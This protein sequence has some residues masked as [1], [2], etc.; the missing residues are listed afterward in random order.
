MYQ[1]LH[2]M[3]WIWLHLLELQVAYLLYCP[4]FA[5]SLVSTLD[6]S[7]LYIVSNLDWL[8]LLSH[9]VAPSTSNS[10]NNHSLSSAISGTWL[11][12]C[13]IYHPL[14]VIASSMGTALCLSHLWSSPCIHASGQT[15][16]SKE[17]KELVPWHQ[18]TWLRGKECSCI[19]EP[20]EN[21]VI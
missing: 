8:H 20:W 12:T 13:Q 7:S 6:L 14:L 2:T 11:Y 18:G 21:S 1:N 5:P 16:Y 4:R 3:T 15:R 19:L 10:L 17:R 9:P